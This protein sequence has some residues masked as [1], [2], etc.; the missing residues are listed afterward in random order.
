MPV[1]PGTRNSRTD[2]DPEGVRSREPDG[3]D[4]A[5]GA[6]P[7]AGAYAS[8]TGEGPLE[9]DEAGSRVSRTGEGPLGGVE[10]GSRASRPA[11]RSPPGATRTSRTPGTPRTSRCG[12][13]VEG[14][15]VAA[16][17]VASAGEDAGERT[18]P[19]GRA[20]GPVERGAAPDAGE[21]GEL[22]RLEEGVE[23]LSSVAARRRGSFIA[24]PSFAVDAVVSPAG[25]VPGPG[26]ASPGGG[27]AGGR[28]ARGSRVVPDPDAAGGRPFGTPAGTG[29]DGDLPPPATT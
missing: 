4:G 8:R 24:R 15:R 22:G 25:R 11:R 28:G 21:V 2:G 5:D 10:A 27:V 14:S 1:P 9:G 18:A 17:D 20:D 19:P 7:P 12:A 29:R 6:E 23:A 3:R 16:S 13:A 26:S